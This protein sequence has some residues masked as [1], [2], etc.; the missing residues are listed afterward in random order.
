MALVM[1]SFLPIMM[2]SGFVSSHF[3]KK[4]QK[5]QQKTKAKFDSDVIEVFDNVRT[6]R[7]LDGEAFET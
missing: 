6:V 1:I 3:I 7:M 4:T 5:F 2:I